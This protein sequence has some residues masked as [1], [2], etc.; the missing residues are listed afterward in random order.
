MEG[1]LCL[2]YY[3]APLTQRVQTEGARQVP[4][5]SQAGPHQSQAEMT[6]PSPI[7]DGQNGREED[8]HICGSHWLSA[9]LA[10]TELEVSVSSSS[11]PS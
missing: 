7:H 6:T 10:F 11:V 5:Q 2:I 9:P 8:L 1:F 4:H 3:T